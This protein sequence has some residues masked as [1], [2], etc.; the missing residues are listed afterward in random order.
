MVTYLEVIY[1]CT[2][3]VLYIAFVRKIQQNHLYHPTA[4][5]RRHSR[6]LP[7]IFAQTVHMVWVYLFYCSGYI[8]FW[9]IAPI[10]RVDYR[11]CVYCAM[12]KHNNYSTIGR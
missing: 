8:K 3:K 12:I 7:R 5:G 9:Q 6:K 11:W 1:K 10:K 4:V 2:I